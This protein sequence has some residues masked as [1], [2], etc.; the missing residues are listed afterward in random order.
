MICCG[1]PFHGGLPTMRVSRLKIPKDVILAAFVILL[2]A[3]IFAA[4]GGA[5]TRPT[6]D[7]GE[8]QKM[9]LWEHG[10]PGALGSDESDKPTLTYFR[11]TRNVSG[12]GVIIAPDRKSVV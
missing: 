8:P 6:I 4:L 10:A 3:S 1:L 11:P 5:Q 2:G 7:A 9:L 12:T